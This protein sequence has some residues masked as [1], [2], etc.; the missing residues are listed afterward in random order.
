MWRKIKVRGKVIGW[1]C[2][3]NKMVRKHLS[4]KVMFDQRCEKLRELDLWVFWGVTGWVV[5]ENF[6]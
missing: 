2:Y 1:S 5:E 6:F 4:G 3:L